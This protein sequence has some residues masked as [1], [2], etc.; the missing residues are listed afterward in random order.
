MCV[1]R[2]RLIHVITIQRI[3]PVGLVLCKNSSFLFSI[4]NF[5]NSDCYVPSLVKKIVSHNLSI[6]AILQ[7]QS[8]RMLEGYLLYAFGCWCSQVRFP[9]KNW[10]CYTIKSPPLHSLKWEWTAIDANLTGIQAKKNVV[11]LLEVPNAGACS[12]IQVPKKGL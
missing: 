7:R 6:W 8:S 11:I 9:L 4:P 2:Y 10:G 12:M 1:Y 3:I 5:S